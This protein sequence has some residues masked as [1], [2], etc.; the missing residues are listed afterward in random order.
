MAN[1][2]KAISD[3][4]WLLSFASRAAK[5]E[6]GDLDELD[7]LLRVAR[8]RFNLAPEA[9]AR[10]LEDVIPKIHDLAQIL[11]VNIGACP[12]LPAIVAN[13]CEELVK[14]S[15]ETSRKELSASSQ[16]P[17]PSLMATNLQTHPSRPPS[18]SASREQPSTIHEFD[19]ECLD[20]MPAEG[21]VLDGYEIKGTIGQGAMGV[22]F[23][24][25]EPSLQ[26]VVAIKMLKPERLVSSD[27]RIRF[28]REARA[29]AAIQH[30]N[31]MT[32][33]AVR[34][35][36]GLPYIVMEYLEGY[37]LQDRIDEGRPISIE[38][39]VGYAHQLAQGLQAA[40]AKKVIHRDIKPDNLVVDRATGVMKIT[41]FG[42]ARV[43]DNANVSQAGY[44]VGTP[45]YMSPEQFA[46]GEIDHRA[47]LFAFGNVLYAL[48]TGSPPFAS[49]SLITLMNKVAKTRPIALKVLRPD[50]P[51]WLDEIIGRLQA[52][53]PM[54]RYASAGDVLRAI[55]TH[56]KVAAP[57]RMN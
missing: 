11:Q 21:T 22:V 26:R 28:Q 53:T 38:E 47:D 39:I 33:F 10:V 34:E 56:A 14:L 5:L 35:F 48:C 16:T 43:Q 6:A 37:S 32:I 20:K 7:A 44:L 27:A 25:F 24:A 30:P 8:D 2:T 29:S 36:K 49:D 12:D 15:V 50:V 13:G 31:V 17:L 46:G 52:K 54:A 40:H 41:D 23:R 45:L 9:V 4:A 55:E 18:G 42:L 51:M 3:R 19:L 1:A 57:K